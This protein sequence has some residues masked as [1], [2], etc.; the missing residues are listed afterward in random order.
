MKGMLAVAALCLLALPA[1]AADSD[2]SSLPEAS[3][4][5]STVVRSDT[6]EI[7]GLTACHKCEWRPKPNKMSAGEQC[8]AD[9]TG[10]AMLAEFECGFS[11]DCQRVCN[12]VR[13]LTQ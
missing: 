1:A 6:L 4:R 3:T 8:G 13:C 2:E 12:F 5:A 11:E 10:K 7:P 9:A